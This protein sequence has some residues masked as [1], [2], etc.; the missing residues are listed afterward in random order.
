M[1]ILKRL[2]GFVEFV[3]SD[4]YVIRTLAEDVTMNYYE[5]AKAIMI[6]DFEGNLFVLKLNKVR[7]T[8]LEGSSAV[9][10]I[11]DLSDLWDLLVSSFFVEKHISSAEANPFDSL[12]VVQTV[13]QLVE[14]Y[15]AN[16]N[17]EI[18]LPRGAYLLD[19]YNFE[20]GNYTLLNVSGEDIH[21]MQHSQ[22]THRITSSKINAVILTVREANLFLSDTQIIATG[23][24]S[25]AIRMQGTGAESLDMFYVEM[26]AN[27]TW[28]TLS[29]I[30]QGFM[31]ACFALNSTKGFLLQNSFDGGFTIQASRI[32]NC[33]Q[34]VL[35]GDTGV[36]LFTCDAIRS[37]AYI[38]VPFG[39]V[40]FDFDFANFNVDGGYQIENGRFDGLGQLASDFVTGG[41]VE[42]EKSRKSLFKGNSGNLRKNTFVGAEWRTTTE[43][44]T[45]LTFNV[46]ENIRAVRT[47][48][49]LVH[50]T[51]TTISTDCTV[52][53]YDSSLVI[54][55]KVEGLYKIEGDSSDEIQIDLI[56]YVSSTT[57]EVIIQ[58]QVETIPNI[59]QAD[60]VVN[61]T[62]SNRIDGL[63]EGDRIYVKGT[64]LSDGSDITEKLN[65]FFNISQ[66]G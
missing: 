21:I 34:Y 2:D 49:N 57:T 61:Y 46:S 13:E 36:D 42:A 51:T 10:F 12:V 40:A 32:I 23:A 4:G 15:G 58:S 60:D 8:Q 66:V 30:R 28:G 31:G 22:L 52:A 45:P 17:D 64:N 11:G 29:R 59:V 24:N 63:A 19:A 53:Q 33:G 14:L 39:A 44:L 6:I 62:I 5:A 9:A 54:D 41:V 1:N 20:L 48:S 26:G 27:T 7:T 25:E 3:D 55:V 56:H 16:A 37:N 35:K 47:F 18:E 50:F 65:T 38:T 43:I